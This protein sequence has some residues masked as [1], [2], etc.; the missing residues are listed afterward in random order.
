MIVRNFY[1]NLEILHVN[2][3]P[4][5]AYYVPA[6]SVRNT[7]GEKR[8]ESD[9]FIL[10][11]G[12]WKFHYFE[13]IYEL[14]DSFYEKGFLPKDFGKIPVPGMWQTHGYDCHQYTNIAYPFPMD[15]PYVPQDNPCGAYLHTFE[16]KR[17]EA[18]PEVYLNFEGVDS[19]FYV[20]LNGKFVG[21]SQVS[22]ST[23]EF[24]VTDFLEEG[25][26]T[27]AVLVLKWC[28]GSYME[29]QDKFRMSGIFRDVY[30][31]LRPKQ[32]IFDYF[33][34]AFPVDDYK[35]GKLEIELTYMDKEIPVYC[36]LK[37]AEGKTVAEK[38][39]QGKKI[40]IEVEQVHLWNAET[41]YL[42]SI[43]FQTENETISDYVGFREIHK[44]GNVV[45][46][47]GKQIKFHGV[48]R[49]DSDP[50]TGFVISQKQMMKDLTLMKKHNI[51]AIRTSHYPNAP[52]F[53][54]L[55]D[56]MGF[57]VID[58][59][60]NE[61]HGTC[62]RYRKETD[63]ETQSKYWNEVIA[64]NP[65]FTKATVDR[66][67]RCVER[68]KNRPSVVIWSMGNECAYGCTFEEALKWTK[69]FDDTRLTHYESARYVSEKRKYQYEN[70]DLYSRMYPSL[71]EMRQYFKEDGSKPYILCEYAHAMGN[72][73]GDLE[74][75][76]Q[77]IQEY[78]GICGGFVWEWC[79]HAIDMGKYVEGRKVYA[80]GGG[81]GEYPN[82]GNFCMDGLVYPNR[83]VHTG[84]LEFKN[85]YRPARVV[86][87][88][89]E[90][91]K[92][93]LHNYMDFLNLKEYVK[94]SWKVLRDGKK[95]GE[96]SW[97]EQ[98][99]PDIPPHQE[100]EGKLC[101]EVP[102]KGKAFLLLSYTLKEK[103]G[104]LPEGFLLGFEEIPLKTKERVNQKVK[105]L[106]QKENAYPI[107]LQ[108]NGAFFNLLGKEWRYQFD[109]RTGMFT[110]MIYGG[111]NLLEKPMG[112]NIWRAPV[113]NDRNVKREWIR[114][115]YDRAFSRA[116]GTKVKMQKDHIIL[117]SDLS[118]QAVSLQRILKIHS[119]WTIYNDGSIQM[120]L[121]VERDTQFPFLPRFGIRLCL[122]ESM[123]AVTYCGMG[124]NENYVDK[125]QASYHGVFFTDVENLHEDYIRPQENGSHGECDYIIIKNDFLQLT[126]MGEHTFSFQASRYT[127]E[128]LARKAYNYELVK[129][130]FTVLCLDYAQSGMGSNS[131]GPELQKKYRLDDKEFCFEIHLKP[132]VITED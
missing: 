126:A 106:L 92:C 31:L 83:K 14:Q 94:L 40:E 45:Y 119:I 7:V 26:N 53:Y 51:N 42:Y 29:D 75:Y 77:V 100:G 13:S 2:T 84:L 57:Y 16:Y 24:R 89:Q 127:Q 108:E 34:K 58:E 10:L 18:A 28:D 98:E 50:V 52:H 32:C 99:M 62:M 79:D 38:E 19:C 90:T 3:M 67:Q 120:H 109:R 93:V 23:S 113:D 102:E 70:L 37:N 6:S 76:F 49:H 36:C 21:Y 43:D 117:E 131:C 101:V 8:I 85:V 69:Q 87:Y 15:P 27:L 5:R 20:W 63:W 39:S 122:P 125:K 103:R 80:Y 72:G 78:D 46:L 59:A 65:L 35:N 68:D 132:Q 71:E 17:Q 82:D 41:P 129:A 11:N 130:P 55:Y 33:I 66:V 114:A 30:L 44:E 112:Y 104:I 121:D 60:D 86:S 48:N 56:A 9:R 116:Y 73:P 88:D 96:G 91:G 81:H 110:Q 105:K 1:E 54:A 47:N 107:A 64:D 118:L 97:K 128:E 95:V 115:G 124:P 74:D 123:T 12:N 111:Q 25:E 4:N 22:H 61:S